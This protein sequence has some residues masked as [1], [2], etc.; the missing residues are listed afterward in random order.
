M[1]IWDEIRRGSRPVYFTD[2]LIKDQSQ[3]GTIV[4]AG[5]IFGNLAVRQKSMR[6][7]KEVAR[8]KEFFT[9]MSLLHHCVSLS[10]VSF[11]LANEGVKR[12]TLFHQ[13]G[14]ESVSCREA[15]SHSEMVRAPRAYGVRKGTK[16]SVSAFLITAI[17]LV[18]YLHRLSTRGQPNHHR[19]PRE[20]SRGKCIPILRVSRSV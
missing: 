10:L 1:Q 19:G 13:K 7:P 11:Q 9:K 16:T 6:I 20:A 14:Q 17:T 5:N 2:G 15:I 18:V 12:K 8:V 4:R 3:S